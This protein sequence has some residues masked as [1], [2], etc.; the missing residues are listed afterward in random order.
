M[1]QT[2]SII[3]WANA[4]KEDFDITAHKAYGVITALKEFGTELSPNFHRATRKK[5]VTT[6]DGTYE[7][8][9][10]LLRKGVN[11]EGKTEF[12][13]LGYRIGLFSSFD[14]KNSSGI[15]ILV[16]VT[17][18]QFKNT[19]VVD[20]PQTLPNFDDLVVAEKL[21]H[22]FKQCVECFDPF[23][24]CIGNNVNVDRY[25]GYWNER[26]PTATHWVNFFGSDIVKQMGIA[27]IEQA[28]VQKIE[29]LGSG[30]FV[31]LKETPINDE[32]E[33]DIKIQNKANSYFGFRNP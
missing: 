5:D 32:N 27:K 14:G 26:L 7:T 19:V 1:I 33:L 9:K 28:P 4:K 2:H 24:G 13:E 12:P 15:S 22:V 21:V 25:N 11:K 30:Y 6:F 3:L 16:G 18:F 23:W 20:L 10:E 29:R 17:D 8:L 31:M